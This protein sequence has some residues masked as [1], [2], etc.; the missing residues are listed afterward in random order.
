VKKDHQLEN[1]LRL[2]LQNKEIYILYQPVLAAKN[3]T[4]VGSEVL[5]RWQHPTEGIIMP[6]DFI[7][8]AER[9]QLILEIGYWTIE[10]ACKQIIKW[11]KS[12]DKP[13]FLAVNL[14]VIQIRDRDFLPRV[15]ELIHSYGIPHGYLEFEMTESILL[16]ESH[17]SIEIIKQLKLLGIKLSIDD[18]GTGY[19]SFDYIRKLPL[20]KIKIDK[21]FIKDIPDDASST[22]IVK[23][24]LTMAEEMQLE[25]VA[26]GVETIGQIQFLEQHHCQYFQGF[27]FSEPKTETQLLINYNF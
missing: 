1:D 9:A 20:D 4:I 17:R 16:N 7:P 6:T 13:F 27:Y 19:S 23:T 2:A 8:I 14:S 22:T 25:V 12:A 15:T 10:E 5:L 18:F 26:E 21:S 24:I 3:R 11:K